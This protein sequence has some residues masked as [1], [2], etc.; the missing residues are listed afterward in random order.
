MPDS[1]LNNFT[2]NGGSYLDAEI[3]LSY[4]DPSTINSIASSNEIPIG[5]EIFM[6]ISA[7]YDTTYLNQF[8]TFNIEDASF[9]NN[10]GNLEYEWILSN[11][12]IGVGLNNID[13]YCGDGVC[14]NNETPEDCSLDCEE[15]NYL[16]YANNSIIASGIFETHYTHMAL[17]TNTTYCYIIKAVV[18]GTIFDESSEVCST[19]DGNST[20]VIVSFED[21]PNDE[22][23][24]VYLHIEP[25]IDDAKRLSRLN[26]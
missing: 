18:N 8:V 16:V 1:I 19:T 13:P 14:N 9:S 11:W 21:Q 12:E 24:Y 23:G 2:F 20:P 17:Y 26:D 3:E 6:S 22:G 10:N 7:E 15:L 5:S 4:Y 25:I